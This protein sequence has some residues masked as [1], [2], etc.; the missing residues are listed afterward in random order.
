MPLIDQHQVVAFES[1]D[2]DGLLAHLILELVDI[3]DFDRATS[4]QT[5][6]VFVEQLRDDARSLEFA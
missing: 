3:K 5:T 6:P 4:E 1:L 2:G